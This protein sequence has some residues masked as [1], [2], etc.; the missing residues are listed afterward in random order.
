MWGYTDALDASSQV[1]Y[2][3]EEGMALPQ[4]RC[5]AARRCDR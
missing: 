5:G 1:I 2:D 3:G 4:R